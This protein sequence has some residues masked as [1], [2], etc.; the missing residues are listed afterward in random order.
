MEEKKTLDEVMD[1]TGTGS[2]GFPFLLL[3]V[4]S[5]LKSQSE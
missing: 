1:L 4:F 2:R 5:A 3:F